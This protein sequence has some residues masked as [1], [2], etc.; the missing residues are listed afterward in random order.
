MKINH[1]ILHVFDFAAC[2]NTFAREE[3]AADDKTAKNYIV[4]GC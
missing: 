3:I 2:E 1:D 4:R